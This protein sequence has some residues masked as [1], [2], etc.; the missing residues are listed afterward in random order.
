VSKYLITGD[1]QTSYQNID[2]CMQAHGQ[3]MYLAKHHKVKGIIDL[4]DLKDDYNPLDLRVL[5]FTVDRFENIRDNGFDL[6]ALMGNHDRFGQY[7]DKRSWFGAFQAMGVDAIST[8]KLIIKDR[9][10]FGC[11][12]YMH[13]KKKLVRAAHK[14]WEKAHAYGRKYR[15]VLLFHCDVQGA[16][17]G[18][19]KTSP[20]TISAADLLFKKWHFC[21]GGHIHKRQYITTNSMYVGNPF[22]FDWGERDQEKGF[23]LYDDVSNTVEV[24]KSN[25]PGWYGYQYLLN[26]K[27]KKILP[28]S[29]IQVQIDCKLSEDYYAVI[30]KT[31]AAVLKAYPGSKVYTKTTFVDDEN[32]AAV[33]IEAA[34]SDLDKIKSYVAAKASDTLSQ[35]QVV[36]YL[37]ATLNKVGSGTRSREGLIFGK[38]KARNVLSYK[39]LDFSFAKRGLTLVT[40][41]NRD[42]PKHSNGSGKTNLLSMLSIA[43]DGQTLKG[44]THDAWLN[45]HTEGRGYVELEIKDVH[46]N[47]YKILRQRK[48]SKLQFFVNGRDDSADKPSKTQKTIN[49]TLGFTLNTL[50]SSVYIDASLPRAFIQGTPKD[51]AELISSF[52]NLERFKLAKDVVAKDVRRSEQEI[53][54]LQEDE[55]ETKSLVA[56]TRQEI[57]AAKKDVSKSIS[58]IKRALKKA[59]TDLKKKQQRLRQFNYDTSTE[60]HALSKAYAEADFKEAELAREIHS[61]TDEMDKQKRELEK[62]QRFNWKECPKCGQHVSTK[63]RH[64]MHS[65]HDKILK[66]LKGTFEHLH[67]D[68]QRYIKEKGKLFKQTEDLKN[69]YTRLDSR[70]VSAESNLAALYKVYKSHKEK[71]EKGS[72]LISLLKSKLH[73]AKTQLRHYRQAILEVMADK[74]ML[75]FAM[76]AFS[77]DGIPLYLNSLA[78]PLLNKM[79]DE[80]SKMFTDGEIQVIFR[81]NEGLLEPVVVNAH[82]SGQI[83]GQSAGEM[84]WAGWISALALRELAPRT[85]LLALDEP[86]FGL[87]D[88]SAKVF[89]RRLPLL[90]SKF[91]TILVVTHNS[92]ISSL[93]SSDST[94]TIEKENKI[95]SLI[96]EK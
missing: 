73:K 45:E 36:K 18:L 75:I 16:D 80:Y 87:D 11:L 28:G 24:L 1:W 70:V 13:N 64:K 92:F 22:C 9:V 95:S 43:F 93:L 4:G 44:Q 71:M 91:E 67:S 41:I 12:P 21:F 96:E 85:N 25:I 35:E 23:V 77:R 57:K 78:C 54:R 65:Q 66:K 3:E 10:I 88:E 53:D 83:D 94:V 84:A 27:V 79:S 52:Q 81:L 26:H 69:E 55:E 39:K 32:N 42:W 17:Y 7:N 58:S 34:S 14:L 63:L 5:D 6:T 8:P 61:V 76:S 38:V 50:K 19:G 20:S 51:R 48:P 31:Q 90:K 62:M 30:S 89:A 46:K 15:K 40:G 72:E 2:T 49:T 68:H 56:A 37:E 82:G 33:F 86:G 60:R 47:K 74:E 29:R 59:K